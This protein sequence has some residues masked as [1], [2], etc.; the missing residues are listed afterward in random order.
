MYWNRDMFSSVGIS[1]PPSSWDEFYVIAPRVTVRGKE[2]DIIRSSVSFG[3]FRNVVH[4]K[5]IISL[6]IMQAGNPIVTQDEL[7]K[8]GYG[9]VLSGKLNY[10]ISPAESALRFYTEFSN[11]AK[12][13]YSW[14]RSLPSSLDMFIAGDLAVYFGYASEL[15]EISRKNPHLNFDVAEVPQTKDSLRK[16]TFGRMRGLAILRS[17]KNITASFQTAILL[18]DNKFVS[19]LSN[20]LKLPP[21]RRNLLA[22]KPTDAYLSLFY[23]SALISRAWID[24]S[25]NDTESIFRNMV[26]RVVS[27]SSSVGESVTTANREM[28]KLFK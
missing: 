8:S 7:S 25:P 27:G 13:S 16:T 24:P 18:S 6:L 2:S 1:T 22:Q 10:D 5:D 28:E 9:T 3:E 14:N 4:A 26:E 20:E 11:P 12:T 15:F 21:V 23:D 19:V 17:S